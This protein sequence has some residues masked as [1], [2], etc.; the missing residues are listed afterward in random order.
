MVNPYVKIFVIMVLCLTF[1]VLSVHAQEIKHSGREA[2]YSR[3]KGGGGRAMR[4]Q[5][6]G[7]AMETTQNDA[8]SKSI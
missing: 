8:I 1:I 7:G 6:F 2:I 4:P 3:Y 5:T